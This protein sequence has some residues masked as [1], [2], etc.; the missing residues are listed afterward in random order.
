MGS[1]TDFLSRERSP[2]SN[3]YSSRQPLWSIHMSKFPL[4][5]SLCCAANMKN[6]SWVLPPLG[7]EAGTIHRFTDE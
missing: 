1:H 4:L 6:L 3:L 2:R 5:L 7:A